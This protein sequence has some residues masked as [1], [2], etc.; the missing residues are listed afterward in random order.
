VKE[1]ERARVNRKKASSQKARE[2]E[3]DRIYLI[4]YIYG[5]D[6]DCSF[7]PKLKWSSPQEAP[8]S[9]LPAQAQ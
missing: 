2:D 7:P 3:D 1:E 4:F 6:S 5:L 8:Q 9:Y